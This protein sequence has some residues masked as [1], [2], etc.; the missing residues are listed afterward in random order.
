MEE[1]NIY[2]IKKNANKK[3]ARKIVPGTG[4]NVPERSD[5]SS[6][7]PNSPLPVLPPH[8]VLSPSPLDPP[9]RTPS[10]LPVAPDVVLVVLVLVARGQLTFPYHPWTPR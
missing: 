2:V 10:A 9:R 8:Q 6:A 1:R 5:W 4:R 3:K 7:D